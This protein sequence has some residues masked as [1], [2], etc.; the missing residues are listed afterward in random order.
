MKNR[1]GLRLSIPQAGDSKLTPTTIDYK[2]IILLRQFISA[3]G[4]ILPRRITNLTAK[5]QRW[6]A[7]AIKQARIMGLLPFVNKRA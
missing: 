3:E 7:R 4:K 6:V 5:E 1:K 2:N